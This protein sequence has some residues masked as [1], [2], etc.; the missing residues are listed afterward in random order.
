MVQS[1]AIC[2]NYFIFR[3]G[4]EDQQNKDHF[5]DY[6]WIYD[7]STAQEGFKNQAITCVNTNWLGTLEESES[8]KYL[9]YNNNKFFVANKDEIRVVNLRLNKMSGIDFKIVRQFTK[10]QAGV[11]KLK[12][13]SS[14]MN[15]NEIDSKNHYK[16]HGLALINEGIK[17]PTNNKEFVLVYVEVPETNLI[18][19]NE[20]IIDD[21]C[22]PP[23]EFKYKMVEWREYSQRDKSYEYRNNDPIEKYQAVFDK[24][25]RHSAV[26]LRE[27]KAI[28]IYSDGYLLDTPINPRNNSNVQL[29]RFFDF[30]MTYEHTFFFMQGPK[31]SK[32]SKRMLKHGLDFSNHVRLQDDE[33]ESMFFTERIKDNVKLFSGL[34]V[35]HTNVFIAHGKNIAQFYL[36]NREFE[37]RTDCKQEFRFKHII[38]FIFKRMITN[39]VTKEPFYHVGV[40]L[41]NGEIHVIASDTPANYLSWKIK[42]DES[43]KS[44]IEGE[45]MSYAPDP[46]QYRCNLFLSKVIPQSKEDEIGDIISQSD[47]SARRTTITDDLD[48]LKKAKKAANNEAP[49]DLDLVKTKKK[50]KS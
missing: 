38:K 22:L 49:L 24:T 3:L 13:P 7:I 21:G 41:E 23:F 9:A 11:I 46:V 8:F 25:G 37:L 42:K 35:I 27:S 6:F 36:K 28:D 43:G 20:L 40:C 1:W 5:G 31:S 45:I 48:V 17:S 29:K 50:D 26:A 47:M 19:V 32:I 39:P 33:K 2:F 4:K 30:Q 18:S 44:K 15:E 10:D 34:L 12:P 14:M 16:I